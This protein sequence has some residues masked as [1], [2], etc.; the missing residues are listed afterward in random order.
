MKNISKVNQDSRHWLFFFKW[1]F[2]VPLKCERPNK[3]VMNSILCR[4]SI[5]YVSVKA[6]PIYPMSASH[7]FKTHPLF[8]AVS[9]TC[10]QMITGYIESLHLCVAIIKL[11]HF[12]VVTAQSL[13]QPQ[14]SRHALTLRSPISS[15]TATART[16]LLK[17]KSEIERN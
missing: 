12:L 15:P 7:K 13:L 6:S 17:C 4:A 14:V 8:C 3:W 10:T 9:T 5:F 11:N 16:I 1:P 2:N